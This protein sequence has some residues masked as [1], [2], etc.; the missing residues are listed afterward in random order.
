MN[1]A[2][3]LAALAGLAVPAA[4]M[5]V[6]FVKALRQK[7]GYRRNARRQADY[8]GPERRCAERSTCM[9]GGICQRAGECP[10][11]AGKKVVIIIETQETP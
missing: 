9:I 6:A 7:P 5:F 3:V 10:L 2:W 11:K 8:F 1:D 4:L